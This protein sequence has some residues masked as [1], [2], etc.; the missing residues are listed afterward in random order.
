M[1]YLVP[2]FSDSY[3]DQSFYTSAII[4]DAY[5][6]CLTMDGGGVL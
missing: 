5:Y 1:C 2:Y 4:P 6:T 3:L